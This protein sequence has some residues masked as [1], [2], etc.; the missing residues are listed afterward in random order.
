[1][2]TSC[3]QTRGVS[4]GESRASSYVPHPSFEQCIAF[5]VG[6]S[7]L[8]RFL[9]GAWM[10]RSGHPST[11]TRCNNDG[12]AVIANRRSRDQQDARSVHEHGEW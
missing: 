10:V 6:A 3:S 5:A 8:L 2:L 7:V 9:G 1:M 4:R 12:Y 11:H